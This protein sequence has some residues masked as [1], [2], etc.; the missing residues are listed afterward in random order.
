VD[1]NCPDVQVDP[2]LGLEVLVNLVEN[3]HRASPRGEAIEMA[4]TNGD[5]GRVRIDVMDRGKGMSEEHAADGDLPRRGL[6]L[7]IV[8]SFLAASGGRL[9]FLA[10][11]GGGT[12]ARVELPAAVLDEDT[13]P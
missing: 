8:R 12:I 13:K 3:A 10:R 9:E 7:E 11:E 4:A 6:G 1:R 5:P 2:A